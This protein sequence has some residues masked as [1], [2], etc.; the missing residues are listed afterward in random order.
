MREV[1]PRTPDP[2]I[3]RAAREG[4]M[5][6]RT[7]EQ[8]FQQFDAA[9]PQ[10]WDVFKKFTFQ[11]IRAGRSRY[12]ADAVLH[13]IRWRT[14]VKTKGDDFKINDHWSAHYARKFHAQFPMYASFFE[15]RTRRAA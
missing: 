4:E 2:Q 10:V 12:S 5:I 15:T 7:I 6:K 9:H 14:A 13:R 8:R 11:L 1:R 3:P